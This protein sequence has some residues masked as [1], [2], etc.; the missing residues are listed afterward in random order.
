VNQEAWLSN[1]ISSAFAG[2]TLGEGIDLYAAVSL[3]DYGNPDEDRLSL[4]AER[5]DWR[6]VPEDD[7]FPRFGAVTFL[8]AQGFRF[9]APAI[10]IAVIANPD[11]RGEF[12]S[13]LLN[14]AISDTGS[15]KGINFN[16]LFTPLQRA[17]VIRFLKYMAYNRGYGTGNA[18]IAAQR[19][20]EIRT[21][22]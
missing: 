16:S 7:L 14:L 17:A 1:Y 3:D 11:R 15:I 8:D 21:R 2:V 9:Y 18:D 4:A 6:L 19:L 22:T 5:N 13:F 10:M 20:E 12:S